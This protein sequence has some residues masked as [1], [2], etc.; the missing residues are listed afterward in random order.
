MPRSTIHGD[1]QFTGDVSFAA[2]VALPADCVGDDNFD[3]TEPLTAEK[4]EHRYIRTLAQ[5]HGTAATAE[6][7]VIHCAHG[8][9]VV[10]A[11]RAGV[12]VAAVGDS[13]VSVD[14]RKNGT[15]ILSGAIVIDNAN[16]AY[17]EEDGTITVPAL[18]A[19]DVLEAVVTVSAGTGTLPQG[20]Y[21]DVIVT[22]DPG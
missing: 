16:A 19:G 10:T 21:V 22:E 7:R 9:G 11:V 17:A 8:A 3:S 18:A 12:V 1:T 14:V 13:T 4:Q 2:N 20:L 5:V 6:R 15:T